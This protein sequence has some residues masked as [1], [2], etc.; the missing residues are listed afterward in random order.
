MFQMS[1]VASRLEANCSG[2]DFVLGVV[3]VGIEE[4][5]DCSHAPPPEYEL[6]DDFLAIQC[7]DDRSWLG[8]HLP[9]S[10]CSFIP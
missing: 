8:P 4:S 5:S 10:C 2:I 1:L 9:R 6:P 7:I 3:F